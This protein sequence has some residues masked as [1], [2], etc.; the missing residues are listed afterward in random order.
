MAKEGGNFFIKYRDPVVAS[1]SSKD[2]VLNVQTGTIFYKR[3]R[4]LYQ[5]RGTPDNFDLVVFPAQ[6]TNQQI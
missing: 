2:I 4:E 5:I 3:N 1:F 6:S